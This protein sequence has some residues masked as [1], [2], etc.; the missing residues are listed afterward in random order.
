[1]P[2]YGGLGSTGFSLTF[3]FVLSHDPYYRSYFMKMDQYFIR[4]TTFLIW[5]EY[6]DEVYAEGDQG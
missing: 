6:W 2:F 5:Q 4:L 3:R 1:M